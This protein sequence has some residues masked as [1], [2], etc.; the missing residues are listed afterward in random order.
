M[1]YVT[2][3]CYNII[4]TCHFVTFSKGDPAMPEYILKNRHLN[5]LNPILF[6]EEECS[7]GH[8]FGPK[9]RN[10]T[11]IHFVIKGHGTFMREG[12][13]YTV[14]AGEAFIIRPGDITIYCAD[15]KDPWVYQWV[16]FDGALSEQF[17]RLDAVVRYR[18]N[19]AGEILRMQRD[20]SNT[21]YLVASKLFLMYS[22]WFS[23]K[24]EKNDYISAVKDYVDAKYIEPITVEEIA[25]QMNL[26]RRYLSRVFKAKTG[27]TIQEYIIWFRIEKA[28]TLLEKSKSVGEAARLCGY[29]DVCNF[30]K[31]FKKETGTSP[32][33]W[34]NK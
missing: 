30:S 19:W 24:T 3:V 7:P 27:K 16:G 26:D 5:D 33:K 28:K 34:K 2:T 18:T 15:Q 9:V 31:I 11:L 1:H 10:Y 17:A 13:R 20:W 6:G 4:K 14:G 29:N 23:E 25:E 32:G 8:S 21:E 12:T 22:E